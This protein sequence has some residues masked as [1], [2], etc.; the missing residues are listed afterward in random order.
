MRKFIFAEKHKKCILLIAIAA[1]IALMFPR[2]LS[3]DLPA[4]TRGVPVKIE[5]YVDFSAYRIEKILDDGKRMYVLINDHEGY[6]QVFDLEGIYQ[7][8]LSFYN[9]GKGALTMAMEANNLYVIDRENNV[10][11]FQDGD[12]VEFVEYNNANRQLQQLNRNDFSKRYEIRLG[13]VWRID[14]QEAICV[15]QRSFKSFIYQYY[16]DQLFLPVIVLILI[17]YR[18]YSNKC[19]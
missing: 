4:K 10:Y 6:I 13:S 8:T 12:F 2:I 11:I 3:Q 19:K 16:I 5:E 14:G 18:T 9:S 17:I 1:Y 15:I 7:Y